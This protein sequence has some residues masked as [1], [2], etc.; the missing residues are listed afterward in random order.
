[1]NYEYVAVKIR[2]E[3]RI[4]IEGETTL[5]AA[6]SII[7]ASLFLSSTRSQSLML[8]A[9]SRLHH[10]HISLIKVIYQKEITF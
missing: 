3:G 10:Y 9:A 2:I 6:L 5:S 1:M 7:S 4:I 8:M